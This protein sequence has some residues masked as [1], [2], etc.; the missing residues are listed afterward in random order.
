VIY[1]SI[2]F[3]N[4]VF[5]QLFQLAIVSV[6]ATWLPRAIV[7]EGRFSTCGHNLSRV[8]VAIVVIV[9]ELA[10]TL[11]RSS[12]QP[13]CFIILYWL[14]VILFLIFISR[15]LNLCIKI[16]ITL[17]LIEK[18][19]FDFLSEILIVSGSSSNCSS[20]SGHHFLVNLFLGRIL[21]WVYLDLV[22]PLI[23]LSVEVNIALLVSS[24]CC[25]WRLIF[26][27]WFHLIYCNGCLRFKL[28]FKI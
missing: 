4:L 16:V 17:Y 8:I 9:Q 15:A 25:S 13:S 24:I 26:I 7:T 27:L 19:M 22:H 23:T 28:L 11:D 2:H 14:F 5:V 20:A 3:D 6:R 21:L 12:L 18:F 1:V 10:T